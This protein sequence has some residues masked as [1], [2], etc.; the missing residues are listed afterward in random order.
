MRIYLIGLPGSG[1]S[2][3]GKELASKINFEFIDLDL[4][5]E[6]N[7]FLFIDEIFHEYGEKY[8]RDLETNFLKE[9]S[10]NDNVVISCGGGIVVR[11]ENKKYMDG[12]VIYIDSDLE[13][14]NKRLERDSGSRPLFKTK[15]LFEIYNERKDKYLAFQNISVINNDINDCVNS[16]I[17]VL[18]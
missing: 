6:K 4:Y 11:E 7:S 3:V 5:I 2:S 13:E 12:L 16:I 15:T 14:I 8:F 18:K 1:K 10:L 9:V 17:E